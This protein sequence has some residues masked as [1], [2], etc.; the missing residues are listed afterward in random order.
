MSRRRL[1]LLLV[2]LAVLAATA[3][4]PALNASADTAPYGDAN[5]VSMFDGNT[6]TG[7]TADNAQNFDVKDAA[8]HTTG[9]ARGWIYYNRQQ[10]GTFRWIFKVRQVVGTGHEPTVLFWGTT[11]PIRDALSAIQF[12]PPDGWCWDYR[13]G[14][15]NGCTGLTQNYSHPTFSLTVWNQCE[16]LGNQVTGVAKMACGPVGGATTHVVTFTD[17]TAAQVGPLAIQVHNAGIQDEYKDL[18]VESPV[19]TSPDEFITTTAPATTAPT[20]PPTTPSGS[21]CSATYSMDSTWQG[22]FQASVVVANNGASTLNGWTVHLTLASGQSISNLWNSVNSGTSGPVTV[23][24]AAYNG[25]VAAGASTSF[26]Y[27]GDGS[28]L[29]GNV[30]C[31]SP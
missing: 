6:L 24:N 27:T 9:N 15:N 17:K 10:V 11:A 7:W 21:G 20:T 13:P 28:L 18:Y 2:G 12:Q 29:P 8:I 1:K 30:S 5:L 19:K 23:K 4:V 16:V 3:G 25:T 14:K 22:G 31:T 26:G